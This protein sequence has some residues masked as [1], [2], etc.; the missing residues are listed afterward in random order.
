MLDDT[1]RKNPERK[2]RFDQ[3]PVKLVE[4]FF[5]LF[6][7]VRFDEHTYNFF[8]NHHHHRR[9]EPAGCPAVYLC[10]LPYLPVQCTLVLSEHWLLLVGCTLRPTTSSEVEARR[11][12]LNYLREYEGTVLRM[13]DILSITLYS[14][15]YY[16]LS[17]R[18]CLN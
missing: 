1:G 12:F 15:V 17:R 2:S 3:S 9:M 10:I 7:F 14:C 4:S 5:V 6:S 8:Y 18:Y 11:P 16:A 13:A